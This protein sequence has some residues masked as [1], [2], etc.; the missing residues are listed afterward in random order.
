MSGTGSAL[1]RAYLPLRPGSLVMQLAIL[2]AVE[3]ILFRLYRVNESDFHWATHFLVGL[4]AA[5]L[6]NLGWLVIR[7]RQPLDKSSR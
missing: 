1:P 5:A 4:T 2:I 7:G 6:W 3:V